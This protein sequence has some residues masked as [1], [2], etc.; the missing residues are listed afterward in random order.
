MLERFP[1]TF[2]LCA[3]ILLVFTLQFGLGGTM[4]PEVLLRLGALSHDRV[5]EHREF[6]R[7]FTATFLHMGP[8]H[9]ALNGVALFQLCLLTEWIYGSTRTLAFY[10]VC[11]LLGSLASMTLSSP[12]LP[13]SVGASGAI[14]GLA[15]LLFGLQLYGE[16]DTRDR[17]NEML[18]YRL[19]LGI[20]LTFGIGI[21]IAV[22]FLPIVDNVAHAGGFGCGM[23]LAA[24]YPDPDIE[25]EWSDRLASGG[26][27]ALVLMAF[28][29]AAVDGDEALSTFHLDTAVALEYRVKSHPDGLVRALFV[30]Q[31]V[32]AYR[33]AEAPKAGQSALRQQLS[34]TDSAETIRGVVGLLFD[35]GWDEEN[36][37]ALERW[38]ELEPDEAMALNALAW[39]HVMR[40]DLEKREPRT[41]LQLSERSLAILSGTEDEALFRPGFL[42][43]KGEIFLQLDRVEDAYAVQS[44]AVA[45]ARAQETSRLDRALVFLGLR[46]PPILEELET[47]LAAIEARR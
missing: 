12:Y 43:T 29:W 47:R 42:D 35:E 24:L 34:D 11:G 6:Y 36:Q 14:M 1:V 4:D 26:G 2:G 41:A 31:M 15:G 40:T 33:L 8:I 30:Q 18:G 45:L 17:L 7:I 39:H 37:I 23:L 3:A 16:T 9:I 5:W 20:G 27:L 22:F 10:L 38:L 25:L 44:E 13:G 21:G 32:N 19:L 28:G 46:S